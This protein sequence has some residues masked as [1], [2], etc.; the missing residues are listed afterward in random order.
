MA[1]TEKLA[2]RIDELEAEY[3]TVLLKALRKCALGQWGLFGQNEHLAL[4]SE[5]P[6][7][8]EELTDLAQVIDA[9]RLR[10]D[11]EPFPLHQRFR[12]ARGRVSENAVGEPKQAQAWL[13]ELGE[14]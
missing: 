9:L 1:K 13:T 4:K 8:V 12:T 3:R 11:L 14:S 2:E 7:E 10:I 5:P 6:H